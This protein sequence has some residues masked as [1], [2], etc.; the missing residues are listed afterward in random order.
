MIVLVQLAVD[1][2][3]N[4]YISNTERAQVLKWVKATNTT[5]VVAGVTDHA[6]SKPNL[7]SIPQGLYVTRD[8]NDI[9]IADTGNSRIQKWPKGAREGTTIAGS[10]T[11]IPDN[12]T[13]SLRSPITMLIDE[14]TD[15]V[16]IADTYNHRIMRWL[17]SMISG[18]IIAGTGGMGKNI[19]QI[20]P[21][22]QCFDV[23]RRWC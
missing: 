11:G 3:K 4:V 22:Y 6:G 7:L 5:A 12:G 23:Y 10:S 15:I 17:P 20:F 9:Y 13:A 16:Y 14:E 19:D 2:D 1:N 18:E 8:G 21:F